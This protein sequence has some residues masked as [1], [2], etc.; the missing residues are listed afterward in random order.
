MGELVYCR[1]NK[2]TT[3]VG[4]FCENHSDFLDMAD[5]GSN[6]HTPRLVITVHNAP[7]DLS[8]ALLH[9]ADFCG[10]P[11]RKGRRWQ[12]HSEDFGPVDAAGRRTLEHLTKR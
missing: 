3:I 12:G 5:D 2:T 8:R 6:T 4:Y 10:P 7:R 9:L 1:D 11:R